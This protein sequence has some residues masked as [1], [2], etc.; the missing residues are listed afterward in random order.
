M[1]RMASMR[2]Q[3]RAFQEAGVLGLADMH[4]AVQ[5][6]RLGRETD[7]RVLLA[8][9]L[10]V[11]ALRGGSVCLELNDFRDMAVDDE[12]VD[13][14]LAAALPWPATGDLLAALR[15]SPLVIGGPAGTLRP[16]TLVASDGGPLLYLDRYYSQEELIR[17]TFAGR[18]ASRPD[19]DVAAARAA[20]AE[21][22]V[23]AGAPTTAPDRQRLAAAVAATEWTTIVAGGPGTGKTHT[24]AR[25]L[26][27]LYRLHGPQLRVALAAPTGKA[28]ATL[29]EAVTEQAGTLGLPAGL[30]ART[31]HRLLG[32]RRG[33]TTRFRHDAHN[34]L[35]YDVVVVDET[36]MVSLTMMA[37]LLEALAPHTRLVLVGDP[38]QLTSV[39]AGAVLDDLVR[40]RA[41]RSENALLA[42]VAAEDL[43]APAGQAEPGLDDAER[44]QLRRGVV[45][46]ARGR[47]FNATIAALADAVRLGRVDEALAVLTG[48]GEAV[49]LVAPGDIDL[50][51]DEVAS[52]GALL[53]GAAECGDVTTALAALRRHRLLCAHRDGPFG[54][55]HW[56]DLAMEWTAAAI[57]RRLKPSGFYPGQPLL[58]T[59]NDYQV[60]VFNGD[61]GVVVATDDGL[62]AAIERGRTPLL[63]HPNTL[64]A[65]QM[66]YAMTI[67]RSQGSQYHGVSVVLPNV[68][69]PLLTRQLLYTAVT[70]AQQRVRVI[71]TQEAVAAAVARRVQRASGLART[72]REG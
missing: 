1:T 30:T 37:R 22:F 7:E 8:V 19:V 63:L 49:S 55:A 25:I 46:L 50:L 59:A 71:A 21:L 4:T 64:S 60:G 14:D 29:T 20:L 15:A 17:R 51:R 28:A 32:W 47:R 40:R 68:E 38:D 67:H 43:A 12:D 9:A 16:L 52:T 11:R 39:D 57:G 61:I 31:V 48:G 69:S 2:P 54:R 62:R 70:R 6:C 10:A 44:G 34:R 35:P 56:A 53:V 66:A 65:V 72:L 5:V 45:R 18:E 13:A 58:I 24:V 36:S 26:A 41:Q 27:L 23:N 42:A 33:S 3:L